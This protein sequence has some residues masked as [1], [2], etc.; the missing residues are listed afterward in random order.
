[1]PLVNGLGL[2]QDRHDCPI[3]SRTA[4]LECVGGH[5]W[6]KRLCG[7]EIAKR[8]KYGVSSHLNCAFEVST[9][10]SLFYPTLLE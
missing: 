7:K 9:Y 1:M 10:S 3:R 2:D 8:P 5:S 6:Y 4:M